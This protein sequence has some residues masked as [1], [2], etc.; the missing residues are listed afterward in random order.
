MTLTGEAVADAMRKAMPSRSAWGRMRGAVTH[1]T[2]VRNTVADAVVDLIDA[3]AGAGTIQFQTSGDVEV[4]TLTYSD[5]AYGAA[6]AGT[7][8]ANSITSDTN[9][10]G[11]TV[12]KS[13]HYDSNT[14][15]VFATAVG[16]SGSDINLSS[17]AV[18][19]GDTVSMSSL[20]YSAPS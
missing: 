1:P 6:A 19:S 2:S 18:G 16:T 9:A 13:R 4:A 15:E 3:G 20:T 8:T 17:L 10:T 5:P 14:T 7:A 12:A 11:G